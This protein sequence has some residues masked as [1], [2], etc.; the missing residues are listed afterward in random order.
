MKKIYSTLTCLF[1]IKIL[2]AQCAMPNLVTATPST[3]CAGGITTLNATVL[4]GASV[5]WFTAPIGGVSVGTSLSTVNFSITP[6][7]STTYYAESFATTTITNV[8]NYTGGMQTFTVPPSVSSVTISASG[9]EGFYNLTPGGKGGNAIGI[10]TVTPGQLLYVYVGGEGNTHTGG[11]NGGG[12]GAYTIGF[13]GGGGGGASD[14]RVGGTA[15]VNRILVAGGGGGCGSGCGSGWAG[16]AGGTG[17]S[18]LSPFG[19]G[20]GYG[21]G[22]A[23][24]NPG[25]CA[26]G[27]ATLSGTGGGGG[28]LN[29]GGA[30]SGDG[31]GG[32]GAA[33]SLGS[34]GNGG[35]GGGAGGGG[36]YYGGAG[37][38]H[39]VTGA[40]GA[41]GGGSSY[42]SSSLTI[43]TGGIQS[44]FGVVE[45]SWLFSCTST[46]RTPVAVT[47]NTTP[48]ISVTSGSI[49]SGNSFSIAAYGANTYTYTSGSS[50]VNPTSNSSF[51]VTGANVGCASTSSAVSTVIVNANPAITVNSGAICIGQTFTI[52]PNGASTYTYSSGSSIVSPTVTTIYSVTGTDI[53]G[54]ISP[55]PAL[56]IVI[57]NACTS[58]EELDN[59]TSIVFYPNPFTNE[60]YFKTE[61]DILNKK[62]LIYN[63]SGQLIQSGILNGNKINC[64]DFSKG[65]YFIKLEGRAQTFKL[66]KEN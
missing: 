32:A 66:V 22:C 12:N 54:C 27:T 18:C 9:A 61:A 36:G 19:V 37:G 58:I 33:G 23:I 60:I 39:S 43:F 3:I 11:F 56:S 34:G 41:G 48:T 10:F 35:T 21:S 14:V 53:L 62:Y 13:G 57:V 5:N 4:G 25:S 45:I 42:S 31:T 55:S 40:D 1:L 29:S 7:V 50:I 28:G 2:G 8:F 63:A 26:G 64:S 17:S 46:S 38:H 30:T 16:G 49:C 51:T 59:N 44:G 24:G 6:A 15:L 47:V 52:I 20:G 65:L